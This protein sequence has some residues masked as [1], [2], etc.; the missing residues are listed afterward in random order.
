MQ[1]A[2]AKEWGDAAYERLDKLTVSMAPAD[3]TTALL[4]GGAGVTAA[5]T[6]PP[7]QDMQLR[8]PAVRTVLLSTD[9]LGESTAS[10]AWASKKFRDAN[11]RVYKAISPCGRGRPCA[12]A[13]RCLHREATT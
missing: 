12:W 6:I 2:A 1:M 3:A 10:Y 5:F 11:P 13:A 9:L 7:F 4:S 8:D